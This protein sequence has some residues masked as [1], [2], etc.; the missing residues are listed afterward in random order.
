MKDIDTNIYIFFLLSNITKT[1]S[2]NYITIQTSIQKHS[3]FHC[4]IYQYHQSIQDLT[5]YEI[6]LTAI[7]L[8][9]FEIGDCNICAVIWRQI[10]ALLTGKLYLS[11]YYIIFVKP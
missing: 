11:F 3:Y 9:A 1:L 4:W 7:I 8:C 5:T 10:A 6:C 2:L